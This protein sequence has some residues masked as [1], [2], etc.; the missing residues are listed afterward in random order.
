MI[1][2]PSVGAKLGGSLGASMS[3]LIGH[4]DYEVGP[5]V[6]GNSI[7]HGK[8]SEKSTF[9][10]SSNMGKMRVRKREFIKNVRC[11]GGDFSIDSIVV[12]P[13]LTEPFPYLSNIART[14]QKYDPK[15]IVYEFVSLVSPYSSTAQMGSIVMAFN[16]NQ[17]DAAYT[18]KAAMENTGGAVSFRPDKNCVFGVECDIAR[19]PYKQ[20]F[21]RTSDSEYTATVAEDYGRLYVAQSGLPAGYTKGAVLGELWVTYD[22]EFD[23]PQMPIDLAGTFNLA[24]AIAGT[25]IIPP[26]SAENSSASGLCYDIHTYEDGVYSYLVFRNVPTG[27]ILSVVVNF[28]DSSATSVFNGSWAPITTEDNGLKA[29]YMLRDAVG[30]D[31][32]TNAGFGTATQCVMCCVEVTAQIPTGTFDEPTMR[33]LPGGGTLGSN[34]FCSLQVFTVGQGASF[35]AY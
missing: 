11:N 14:F 31:W 18:N 6:V 26:S 13:G 20:Y 29:H 28:D 25:D 4:G 1:G 17:G 5:A 15:G 27:S 23:V 9:G 2:Q 21:V 32:A 34:P 30:S 24:G 35:R 33:F 3:R 19:R 8:L 12:Q 7:I 22:I 10:T 16:T